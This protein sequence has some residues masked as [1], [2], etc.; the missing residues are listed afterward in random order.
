MI[1]EPYTADHM[2]AARTTA[3]AASPAPFDGLQ[4]EA[5]AVLTAGANAMRSV[6]ER[7]REAYADRLAQWRALR[8]DLEALVAAGAGSPEQ[9]DEG[10]TALRAE[11]ESAGADLVHCQRELARLELARRNLESAWLFL[12]RGDTS[13]VNDDAEP[14]SSAQVEMRILQAQE[15]ERFRLAQEIHDGPAQVLTNAIFQTELSERALGD[16]AG[17]ARLEI[18]RM[19]EALRREL[20]DLRSFI[21]RLR[22]PALAEQGLDGAIRDTAERVRVVTGTAI[23]LDLAAPPGLL[24]E[25]HQTVVLRVTQEA[26]QNVRKHA[27]AASIRVATSLVGRDWVLEIRDDGRG[28][29]LDTVAAVGRRSFG[30]QFMRERA[31]LIGAQLEVRSRSGEGTVVRLA[32]PAGE[33][34]TR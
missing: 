12:E 16:E 31:A 28:F 19:R 1:P 10:L 32:I 13:L 23:S 26:L 7:Y 5:K 20:G 14:T 15:A 2:D 18:R 11:V 8:S 21:S 4:A 33:E 3:D 24:P 29:D 17:D 30:V 34:E 9:D 22:P 6:Q 25:A 27:A